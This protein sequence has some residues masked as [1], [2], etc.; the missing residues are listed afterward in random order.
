MALWLWVVNSYV[1]TKFFWSRLDS[2]SVP[3]NLIYHYYYFLRFNKADF[4]KEKYAKFYFIW[5]LILPPLHSCYA[6][7]WV[8]YLYYRVN[9]TIVDF[10]M[11]TF[12]STGCSKRWWQWFN[13]QWWTFKTFKFVKKSKIWSSF[14]W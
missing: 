3:K 1:S 6:H 2:K 12:L 9:N 10:L 11:F 4:R 8:E 7:V 13:Q 14:T 5:L